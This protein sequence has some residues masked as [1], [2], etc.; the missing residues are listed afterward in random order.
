MDIVTIKLNFSW[1]NH[2]KIKRLN[3]RNFLLSFL[4]ISGHVKSDISPHH[5]DLNIT[6]TS[7]FFF[8]SLKRVYTLLFLLCYY[9]LELPTT[10]SISCKYNL[11]CTLILPAALFLT[12]EEICQYAICL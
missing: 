5:S 8:L 11:Y 9:T 3:T 7:S 1:Q 4:N 12:R 6:S 2:Q 10:Q